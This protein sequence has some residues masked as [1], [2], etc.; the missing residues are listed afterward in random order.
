M[1]LS[2]LLAML[3]VTTPS[4]VV[5]LVCPGV[6]GFLCPISFREWRSGMALQQVMKRDHRSASAAEDTTTFMILEMVM[7]APLFGVSAELLDMKKFPIAL[8]FAFDL[9]R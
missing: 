4:A 8:L 5:L 9:E 6:G 3:L 7:T 2:L 1:D